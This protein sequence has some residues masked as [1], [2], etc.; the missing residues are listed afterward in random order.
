MANCNSN[1]V[2]L[3][4]NK[5]KEEMLDVITSLCCMQAN[6][7]T[8]IITSTILLDKLSM[9][10]KC[11]NSNT[12]LSHPIVK[13]EADFSSNTPSTTEPTLV[14]QPSLLQKGTFQDLSRQNQVKV[15]PFCLGQNMLS[16]KTVFRR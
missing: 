12:P 1:I 13:V 15:I 4:R 10:L 2:D 8:M 3:E 11:A 14:P 6:V 16:L 5:K 7:V 9:V